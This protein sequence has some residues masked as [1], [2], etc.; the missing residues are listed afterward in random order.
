VQLPFRP[1]VDDALCV[2]DDTLFDQCAMRRTIEL[3]PCAVTDDK[4]SR[5]TATLKT[6]PMRYAGS[7]VVLM[8]YMASSVM[9]NA[10][11]ST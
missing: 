2:C 8:T 5:A 7:G 4:C 1:I 10:T 6:L 11:A 9:L 3:Q